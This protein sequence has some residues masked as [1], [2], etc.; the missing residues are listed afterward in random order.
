MAERLC[1][2][3]VLGRGDDDVFLRVG[4]GKEHK[5][6]DDLALRTVLYNYGTRYQ[7]LKAIYI[8]VSPAQ[9][10]RFAR[11]FGKHFSHSHQ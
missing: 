7:V 4:T 9:S 11:L 1:A 10:G 2:R 6:Q 3:V 8:S 5:L